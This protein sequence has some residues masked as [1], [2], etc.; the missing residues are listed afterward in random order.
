MPFK[1]FKYKVKEVKKYFLK[2]IE[3]TAETKET[4]NRTSVKTKQGQWLIMN[5]VHVHLSG[6]KVVKLAGKH[7]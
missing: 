4:E 3:I 1:Q 7:F 5:I 2:K 6:L